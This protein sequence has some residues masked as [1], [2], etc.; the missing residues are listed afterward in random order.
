MWTSETRDG[1]EYSSRTLPGNNWVSNDNAFMFTAGSSST[2]LHVYVG[3]TTDTRDVGY[4][5]VD[6]F[7]IALSERDP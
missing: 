6:D 4:I 7:S 3:T 1:E 5:Y 2:T